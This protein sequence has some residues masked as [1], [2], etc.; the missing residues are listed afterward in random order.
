MRALSLAIVLALAAPRANA[1]PAPAAGAPQPPPQP[2]PP[3][4]PAAAPPPDAG[5]PV[6]SPQELARRIDI[7]WA[8]ERELER[9]QRVADAT[10]DEV[11]SLIPLSHFI[12][13]FVDVGAFAVGG[14]GSGIRSDLGNLVF[15]KYKG[16]I[17]GQWVFMGDPLS[18]AINALG[19]PADTSDSRELKTDTIK[20]KGRPSLIVNSVGLSI[21][22]DVGHRFSI[23]SLAELLPRTGGALLDVELAYVEYRPFDSVNF[24]IDAG[25]VDSVLGIEYRFQDAPRR[26]TVTPSLI[27]RYLCGRPYG[28]R[29]SL[30][31]G[32]FSTYATIT[33]GD[34]FQDRFEPHLSLHANTMPTGSAHVQ[35]LLPF[36]QGLEIGA[37]GAF[38]P[39]D[40]Q[41]DIPVDQWHVG[42]DLRLSDFHRFDA[43]AEL[44]RGRQDG[45]GTPEIPCGLA[46]CLDY[47]GGYLLVD[48]RMN[49]WLMPYVRVDWRDA[50][51]VNGAQFAYESHVL[52]ATVGVHLALTYR[53]VGKVEYTF[54]HELDGIP[55]FPDDILTSSLVVATD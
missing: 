2:T 14:D 39:Q 40:N 53:I 55:Q 42:F 37:S 41:P 35:W 45:A 26:T 28:I 36:G 9:G 32:P 5:E 11:R 10:H 46:P 33:D 1:Q 48:R 31:R 23:A 13:V 22:K 21:A 16:R 30:V 17:A 52:R 47:K 50:V 25:K 19:E 38:G 27:C 34:S 24:A 29:L 18:T 49:T 6:L 54:N 8:K 7:L 4:P 20:S 12:K 15:S 44:V 51:H 43:F 3:P